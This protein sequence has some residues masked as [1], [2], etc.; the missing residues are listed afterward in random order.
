MEIVY[1]ER[2]SGTS[3]GGV[4]AEI[5]GPN[6]THEEAEAIRSNFAERCRTMHTV[7]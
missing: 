3:R 2:I 1:G 5:S 6:A 4:V 7:W